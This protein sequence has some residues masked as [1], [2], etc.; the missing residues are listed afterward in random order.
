MDLPVKPETGVE[1]DPQRME[2]YHAV[3]EENV[4]G[5]EPLREK[6]K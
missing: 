3:Y 6:D 1:L 4:K 5:K 2:E